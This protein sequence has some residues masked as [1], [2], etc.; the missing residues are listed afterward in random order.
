MLQNSKF[1]DSMFVNTTKRFNKIVQSPLSLVVFGQ[2]F[3]VG[4]HDMTKRPDLAERNRQNAKYKNK[5][6]RIYK[7]WDGMK[8]RCYGTTCK[9]YP[10][11]GG[12][13]IIICDEWHLDFNK[14]QDW[15]LQN[16]YSDDLTL[17]RI[18]V[19]GNYEPNNCRWVLPKTQSRNMRTN[20]N[21]TYKGETH[22]IAEWAEITGIPRKCLE[23]RVRNWSDLDRVF[24]REVTKNSHV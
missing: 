13:G 7:I 24:N 4:E 21:I 16:G 9:D 17:D 15:A 10:R 14:F 5:N 1:C 8:Q 3:N 18:D 23:Y 2:G 6:K 22:C 19:N 11:Y 20:K 12:R